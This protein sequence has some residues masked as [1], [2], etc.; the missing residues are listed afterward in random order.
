VPRQ[1]IEAVSWQRLPE[2]G[3]IWVYVPVRPSG[4]PGEGLPEADAAFPV[5]ESYVDTVIEGAL[6]Y[7]TD[8]ARELIETTADWS[9]Y[10]L[11]DRELARRPWVHDKQSSA[12]DTLLAGTA[13]AAT[14]IPSRLFAEPYAVRWMTDKPR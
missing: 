5:L 6:E 9:Q 12:V 11:N 14:Y 3:H 8:Y 13:P 10:W 4:V 7:G 2:V 1:E